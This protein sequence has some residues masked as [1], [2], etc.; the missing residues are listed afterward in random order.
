MAQLPLYTIWWTGTRHEISVCVIHCTGGD[1]LIATATLVVA[2]VLARLLGWRLF[3]LGMVFTAIALGIGYTV[4]SEWLNVAVW[5]SWSYTP[6]MPVLPWVGT[7]LS[8]LLQW[9][10]VPGLAFFDNRSLAPQ[11]AG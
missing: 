6:A 10:L 2:A 1:V 7:G 5:R 8:P 4:M 9:L 3:G 11:P